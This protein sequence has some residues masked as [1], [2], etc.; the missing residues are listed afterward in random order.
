MQLLVR[1]TSTVTK[2]V[3]IPTMQEDSIFYLTLPK[4]PRVPNN[5]NENPTLTIVNK[6]EIL[7]EPCL[8]SMAEEP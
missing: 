3:V 7:E 8:L 5:S 1:V 2:C 6:I 4:V